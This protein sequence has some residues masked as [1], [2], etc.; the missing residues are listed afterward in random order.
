MSD[1]AQILTD[2]EK[3][4][5]FA[6]AMLE[7][8]P[9][10]EQRAKELPVDH[11]FSP[12]VYGRVLHIPAG[13]II[14]GRIHKEP[15]LNILLCGDIVIRMDDGSKARMSAPFVFKSEAGRQKIGVALTDT[16]WMTV[17]PNP[18][19]ETD[20]DKLVALYTVDTFEQFDALQ[21]EKQKALAQ[22][23]RQ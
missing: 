11:C 23:D 15:C 7:K 4:T 16:V 17:H 5:V 13:N 9:D 22:G 20:P 3:M 14:V 6:E 21:A 12:G 19:D 1:L 8:Y 18:A 10:A 2:R